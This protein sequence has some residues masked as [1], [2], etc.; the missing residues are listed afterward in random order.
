[1]KIEN[2]ELKEE[3]KQLKIDI[4]ELKNDNY[5]LKLDVDI[6]KRRDDPITVREGFVSLE[7]H[8]MLEITGSKKKAR[9]FNDVKILFKDPSYSVQ[10][11]AY[12]KNHN[13]TEDHINIISELKDKGNKSAH[14]QR[15]DISRSEWDELAISML[16]DPTD[17]DDIRLTK[18]LLKLLESYTGIGSDGSLIISKP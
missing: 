18:D 15:P 11:T 13:I 6:L 5:Q 1:M 16:D 7:K 9:G 8:I 3:N 2:K 12:L 14:V 17:I 4:I 10:C